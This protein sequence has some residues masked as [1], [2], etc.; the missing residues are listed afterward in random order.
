MLGQDNVPSSK[1]LRPLTADKIQEIRGKI[2]HIFINEE[3]YQDIYKLVQYSHQDPSLS[4][5]SNRAAL[6]LKTIAKAWAYFNKRDFVIR[7]DLFEIFPFTCGHRLA[8]SEVSD[9]K[10]E[11]Q[12]ALN[13]LENANL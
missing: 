4:S 7:D 8:N 5:L 12:M 13:I 2:D 1:H 6:D 3:I 11:H 10:T 9:T